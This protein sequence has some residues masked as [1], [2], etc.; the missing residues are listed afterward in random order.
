MNAEIGED[1]KTELVDGGINSLRPLGS[2]A[3]GPDS[4]ISPGRLSRS[5]G[6]CSIAF[7]RLPWHGWPVCCSEVK[8][9]GD[10]ANWAVGT[11]SRKLY[12]GPGLEC[13]AHA[14]P[15]CAVSLPVGASGTDARHQPS[16]A[17]LALLIMAIVS[18][19]SSV[20]R[21]ARST[22]YLT[23]TTPDGGTKSSG[24]RGKSV[25]TS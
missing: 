25:S 21:L 12:P 13:S 15:S 3:A 2:G 18:S 1:L 11:E 17:T 4:A 20:G 14:R 7:G 9:R 24:S 5:A 8:A 23:A 10:K 16:K 22:V 6:D 19:T